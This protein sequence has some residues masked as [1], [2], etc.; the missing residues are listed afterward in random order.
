M[1]SSEVKQFGVPARTSLFALNI[2]KG[3]SV[4][5]GQSSEISNLV[6]GLQEVIEV[7]G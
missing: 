4:L 7:R 5:V 1:S 2:S 3:H 6:K